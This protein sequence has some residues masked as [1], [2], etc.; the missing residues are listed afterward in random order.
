M[1]NVSASSDLAQTAVSCYATRE[2]WISARRAGIGSS[3]AAS[4]FEEEIVQQSGGAERPYRS[5]L[6][7]YA[8]KVGALDGGSDSDLGGSPRVEWG[9]R[10]EAVVAEKWSEL[11]GRSFVPLQPFTLYR[12]L[13]LPMQATPDRLVA[14]SPPSI[15]EVKTAGSDQSKRWGE[16]GDADGVPLRYQVQ[17]QH[18][19]AVLGL[20]E[21]HLAVLIGGNDFRCYDIQA[22][23][24]FKRILEERIRAFWRCVIEREAPEPGPLDVD[25]VRQ[26]YRSATVGKSLRIEAVEADALLDEFELAKQVASDAAKQADGAKARLMALL[27]DAEEGVLPSGR[28]LLWREQVR[29]W[30]PQPAREDRVRVFTVR[31]K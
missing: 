19:L 24:D 16:D 26:L 18:Q 3:D 22:N 27:G 13:D 10:L 15:L 9:N 12:R 8:E 5:R 7:L 30:K 20:E 21:A 11:A 23:H 2:E 29:K 14:G 17:V 4:L 25:V 31:D 1:R 28:T 6:A